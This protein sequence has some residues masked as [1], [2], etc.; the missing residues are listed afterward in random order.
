VA[1]SFALAVGSNPARLPVAISWQAPVA[2]SRE[3]RIYDLGGRLLRRIALGSSTQGAISW[4]GRGAGGA[5]VP[6]GVYLMTLIAGPRRATIR[7]VLLQ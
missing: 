1:V 6:S 2:G 7:F 5:R 4:D 3:L